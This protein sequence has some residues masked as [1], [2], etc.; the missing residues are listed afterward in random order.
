MAIE[1]SL[2]YASEWSGYK[3]MCLNDQ[4]QCHAFHTDAF[5]LRVNTLTSY[6]Y[7]LITYPSH[8]IDIFTYM[9]IEESLKYASEWSGYKNMCLNDQIQ[10]HAFHT[11]AFCLR[12]NTLTSYTYI[13]RQVK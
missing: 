5:C 10:C 1:E 13:N 4:I 7:L 6:T 12:V 11:D 2:K 8:Y 9:A 3:N